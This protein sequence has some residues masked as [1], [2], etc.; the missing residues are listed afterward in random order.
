MA[1][2]K[3]NADHIAQFVQLAEA[4]RIATSVQNS[5]PEDQPAS[6]V[7]T[8]PWAGEGK[9]ML[10]AG[11]AQQAASNMGRKV[12]VMDVHWRAPRLHACFQLEQ[13]FGDSYLENADQVLKRVQETA[14]P[15][16]HLLTAPSQTS[17]DQ[18]S[19]GL[20]LSLEVLE[21]AKSQYD[22]VI[23]DTGPMFPPNRFMLD[24]LNYAAHADGTVLVL[25][26]GSTPREMAKRATSMFASSG[27][28][29]LGLV[30][31]QWQ[32][33]LFDSK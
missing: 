14:I 18:S 23:L 16:L 27:A 24:P 20:K 10:A 6:L 26:G 15:G 13:N 31:N 29:L 32:N 22:L 33:P 12:L 19:W 1:T 17:A 25:L 3:A 9:T 28:K 11:L 4:K 8:S 30:L 21:Q 5:L 7:I 2:S